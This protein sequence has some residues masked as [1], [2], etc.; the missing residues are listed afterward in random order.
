MTEKLHWKDVTIE[1][2]SDFDRLELDGMEDD[3]VLDW[4]VK[5]PIM[6]A[7]DYIN[8]A[9]EECFPNQNFEQ[10][11]VKLKRALIY[12]KRAALIAEYLV[13]RNES[14]RQF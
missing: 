10:Y 13:K 8:S 9:L 11:D 12:I 7:T 5:D 14:D 1:G 3:D 4:R 6:H 2:L